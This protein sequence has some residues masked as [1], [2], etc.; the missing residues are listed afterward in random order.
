[1]LEGKEQADSSLLDVIKDDEFIAPEDSVGN[2][3]ECHK[4]EQQHRREVPLFDNEED[5]VN[6]ETDCEE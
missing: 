2:K 5:L 3:G 4:N 6:Y 1:M